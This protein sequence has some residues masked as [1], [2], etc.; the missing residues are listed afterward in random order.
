VKAGQAI[1]SKAGTGA[2]SSKQ[3]TKDTQVKGKDNQ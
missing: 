1:K 3:D 2:K